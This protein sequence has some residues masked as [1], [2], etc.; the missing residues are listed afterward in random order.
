ML[1]LEVYVS[2]LLLFATCHCFA[3]IMWYLVKGINDATFH[4]S[5][6]LLPILCVSKLI[7]SVGS[8]VSQA[9]LRK[10]VTCSSVR[11][12]L[13]AIQEKYNFVW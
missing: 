5:H 4:N 1:V 12:E 11:P 13:W 9:L 3:K 2:W 10:F 6:S 7:I 8:C